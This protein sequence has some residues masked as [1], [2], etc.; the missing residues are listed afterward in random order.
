MSRIPA[1]GIELCDLD[2]ELVEVKSQNIT[3]NF[4]STQMCRSVL[5]G[6]FARPRVRCSQYRAEF[7][8]ESVSIR[9]WY[10]R[11]P[12]IIRKFLV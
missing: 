10:R 2:I 9:H 5:C 8:A 1:L 7:Q 3:G 11:E 12:D 4:A 6:G